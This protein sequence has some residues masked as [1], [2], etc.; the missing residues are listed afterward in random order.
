M[1]FW[2]HG[3]VF[4]DDIGRGETTYNSGK[5][6][7]EHES[8]ANRHAVAG[9]SLEQLHE[10]FLLGHLQRASFFDLPADITHF[11]HDIFM[12]TGEPT[13]V[14]KNF[15]GRLKVVLTCKPARALRA[16]EKHTETEEK[17]RCEL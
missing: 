8:K 17:T 7:Q 13:E 10:L 9:A 4:C 1:M 6:L 5:G 2:N 3:L 15:L 12:L 11:A 16:N 14:A